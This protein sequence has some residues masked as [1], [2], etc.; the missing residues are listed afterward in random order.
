M[1]LPDVHDHILPG[2]DDSASGRSPAMARLAVEERIAGVAP[3]C[4]AVWKQE[5]T[6]RIK[7]SQ[8][9]FSLSPFFEAIV[10][11]AGVSPRAGVL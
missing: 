5:I 6:L 3:D 7:P 11:E 8:F 2:L 4:T 10:G 9:A 1:G